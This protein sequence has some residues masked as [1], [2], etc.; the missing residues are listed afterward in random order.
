MRLQSIPRAL[1]H[2]TTVALFTSQ[3]ALA[4]PNPHASELAGFSY[5]ELFARYD[6]AGTPCGVT[7]QYCCTG[8][9]A[10][11]TD[12]NT[13]ALCVAPTA[14]N[15]YYSYY[16]TT[17]TQTD[18]KTVTAV[19]STYIGGAAAS[20]TAVCTYA[21][22]QKPCGPICC[23]SD[24][25][26]F[27]L[28]Q[29]MA[30]DFGGSSGYYSTAMGTATAT[31]GAPL[32][33]TSVGTTTATTTAAPTATV[34]FIPPVAT[35]AN[36]TVTGEITT[37]NGLSGGAIAG[38]VIG[39][40]AALLLLGLILF[41][42]CLRGLIDGCLACFG[43]GG[44]KSRRTEVE[45]YERYSHHTS[46]GQ[47]RTWYGAPVRTSS[48]PA[49]KKSHEGRNILGVLAGLGALWAILGL[50]RR[51]DNKE[52]K[53]EDAYTEYS[54]GSTSYYSETGTSPSKL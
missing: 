2:L 6:C 43:C 23:A 27:Q 19:M 35:G 3:W 15:G 17:Y 54:Y 7:N 24:Q 14:T 12:I 45:E 26:C 31:P 8:G 9:S 5:N 30:A 50:K 16:T 37:N 52:R 4:N 1:A 34:P 49:P 47:R 33:P 29:C 40:L 25:Y 11:V 42:C 44:R 51:H 21:I 38:I 18:L 39:V 20:P 53:N 28:G 46:G 13:K 22:G 36:V 10:C 32:R 41:C 48:R